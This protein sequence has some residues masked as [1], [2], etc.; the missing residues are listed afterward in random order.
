LLPAATF[1]FKRVA[2]NVTYLPESAVNDL[3]NSRKYDPSMHGVFFV[4][5]KLD[6]S[7]FGFGA[8]RREL[9]AGS[10]RPE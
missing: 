7:L 4:Q 1:G 2:V 8:R 5:L 3:T 10:S 6:A 9:F